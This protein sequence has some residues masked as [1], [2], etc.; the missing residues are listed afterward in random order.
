MKRLMFP[1]V[2]LVIVAVSGCLM[3]MNDDYVKS[4]DGDGSYTVTGTFID[5]S[6]NPIEGLTVVLTGESTVTAVTDVDGMYMFE[7]V[8]AGVYTINPGSSGYG[9]M[10]LVVT[11]A[12]DVGT[13]NSG[14]G[15]QIGGDYTCSGC[16]K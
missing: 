8:A 11:G 4:T 1:V 10:N 13:N 3:D 7:N 15:G 6:D 5:K 12:I 9:S 16:H 14:H 2:F